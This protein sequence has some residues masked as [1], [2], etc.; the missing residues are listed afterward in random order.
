MR[1]SVLTGNMSKTAQ[2]LISDNLDAPIKIQSTVLG[3]E[4]GVTYSDLVSDI[5]QSI[6][7]SVAEAEQELESVKEGF[8]E[9]EQKA[10]I[11]IKAKPVSED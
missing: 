1:I 4:Q 2:A 8:A 5:E 3:E 6:S 7:D 11:K 9:T 10:K